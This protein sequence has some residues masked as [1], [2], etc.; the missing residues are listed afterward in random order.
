MKIFNSLTQLETGYELWE[1]LLVSCPALEIMEKVKGEKDNF[2]GNYGYD[3]A[4]TPAHITVAAFFAKEAMEDTL[5]RWIQNICSLQHSFR[6]VLNNYG[7]I[8][9]HTIYIRVQEHEPFRKLA[10]AMRILDGFIQS[11]DCPPMQA[12]TS[13]GMPLAAGLPGSVYE[14]A[15]KEYAQRS[16]HGCFK[17]D[18]LFLLKLDAAG[19]SQLFNSFILPSPASDI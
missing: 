12:V 1:Y 4:P 7:A 19:N 8:P 9:P 6:A 16:F 18:R 17:V 14:N 2:L 3:P 11:N 15:I 5:I 10:N 13:P